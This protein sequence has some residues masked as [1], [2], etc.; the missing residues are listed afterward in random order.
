VNRRSKAAARAGPTPRA[1]ASRSI[2]IVGKAQQGS[3]A[4]DG[5]PRNRVAETP[6]LRCC[7]S[8]SPMIGQPVLRFP[9]KT[10]AYADLVR[11]AVP[12]VGALA[13]ARKDDSPRSRR[14]AGAQH[15]LDQKRRDQSSS[16]PELKNVPIGRRTKVSLLIR[17]LCL[18]V[19][20]ACAARGSQPIDAITTISIV[21]VDSLLYPQLISRLAKDHSM[22]LKV[23]PRPLRNDP[24]IVSLHDVSVLGIHS[25]SD[26]TTFSET[27]AVLGARRQ[28]LH[29]L[30][31]SATDAIEDA[32]CPGALAPP[33]ESVQE[34]K[35]LHC[36]GASYRSVVV[37]MPRR[38]G[39]HWP[40]QLDERNNYSDDAFSVRV[41]I[42]Y[43]T[44]RG[45]AERSAD[46]VFE[47]NRRGR[48]MLLTVRRLLWVE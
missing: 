34:R 9:K 16:H 32:L 11:T 37:S 24:R 13:C 26:G 23:D 21:R 15:R 3:F 43:M 20:G 19:V 2:P 40:D 35:R 44:A 31:I 46:Y 27:T 17:L 7:D 12:D 8:A 10:S 33:T 1:F 25:I 39:P 30:S 6:I 36:P 29:D 5:L 4:R 42:R 18:S 45:S 41:I 14:S 38:G 48:W 22:P 47:R 28:A